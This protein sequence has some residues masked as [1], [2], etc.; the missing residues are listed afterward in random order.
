MF[1]SWY[2]HV[3]VLLC[4]SYLPHD[5]LAETWTHFSLHIFLLTVKMSDRKAAFRSKVRQIAATNPI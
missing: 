5:C 4:H 3:F 1:E 2:G